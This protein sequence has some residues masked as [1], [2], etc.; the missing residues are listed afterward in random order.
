MFEY[1]IN[2]FLLLLNYLEHGR[3]WLYEATAQWASEREYITEQ[4]YYLESKFKNFHPF[5]IIIGFVIF[6]YLIK[7][8]IK[9]VVQFWRSISTY[10]IIFSYSNLRFLL[11][12]FV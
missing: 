4:V 1:F 8:L 11:H 10:I 6:S 3:K 7:K 5:T 9:K 12:R 2:Y